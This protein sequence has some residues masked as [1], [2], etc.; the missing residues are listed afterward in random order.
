MEEQ[1]T[2]TTVTFKARNEVSTLEKPNELE[3]IY[4]E[5]KVKEQTG[6]RKAWLCLPS[7]LVAAALG[8]ICVVLASY[9]IILKI[10]F[11]TIMSE[12]LREKNNLTALSQQLWSEKDDLQRK[13]QELTRE[14]DGLNWTLGVIMEYETFPVNTFCLQNVCKPCLDNWVL[15]QSNCYLF[16]NSESSW[17]WST[18]IKS[19]EECQKFTAD[20]VVIESQEE[21]EFI[22]NHT[23][24][25]HDDIHGY[26]IGLRKE[27][28]T[29]SWMWLDGSNLTAVYWRAQ[30]A[31]NRLNCALTSPHGDPQ[32]KWRKTSCDMRNRF[33]CETRALIKQDEEEAA[34]A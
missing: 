31:N 24:V 20:L 15:F 27:D 12:R 14:R 1:L 3:I 5:I 28:W 30:P 2:Y 21:Q 32:A 22:N 25:Y 26:W 7:H 29:E 33:I 8:I 18:W 23:E 13:T 17:K 6:R 16:R 34:F 11:Y 19:Q 4:D 9:I 10:Q